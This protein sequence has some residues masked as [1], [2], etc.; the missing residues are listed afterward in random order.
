MSTADETEAVTG[1]PTVNQE[2]TGMPGINQ[3]GSFFGLKTPEMQLEETTKLQ[4]VAKQT[5]EIFQAN[6]NGTIQ[7]RR[8]IEMQRTKRRI[9]EQLENVK[10]LNKQ[11]TYYMVQAGVSCEEVANFTYQ[12]DVSLDIY[13]DMVLQ[14]AEELQSV[15]GSK[16]EQSISEPSTNERAK[17]PKLELTTYGGEPLKWLEFWEQFNSVIHKS[18]LA[19]T[20]K[21]HY[22]RKVLVGRA[23]AVIKGLPTTEENY[24]VAIDKLLKEFGDDSKLRSAHVKAIRDIPSVSNAHN[25]YKLRR[26]Y[27]EISANYA[28]LESMNYEEQVMCLVEETVMKLPRSIRYEITKDDRQWTQWKFPQF[29]DKLWNYLKACEE[30]EPMESP[31]NVADLHKRSVAHT[32]TNRAVECVYCKSTDH[33]SFQ[34]TSVVS[35]A[36]RKAILQ[37]QKRCFNCTRA[38][39]TLRQ[40]KSRNLCYHCKGKHHSSICA[41]ANT[42]TT[43]AT[44]AGTGSST[45]DGVQ[46]IRNGP[47]AYQTVQ[48]K[49]GGEI[50]RI[51]L[52]SGSGKSYISREHSRK[53]KLKP[54]RKESRIIGTVNGEMEVNCPIYNLEVNGVGNATGKF[55]T[56]FAELDLFMLSSVP[57]IHPE[58][59]RKKYPHLKG[60]WFSDVSGDNELPIHAI[61]GVKDYA[62][63]RTGRMVKGNQHEPIAEETTLGWTLMGAIQ[64]H[65]RDTDRSSVNV[66]VEKPSSIAEDFKLLYDL[67]ILGIKD[68]SE[69]VYEEFKDNITRLSDGRYSVKLPWRKGQYYLPNNKQLCETRLKSLLKK[70]RGDQETLEAYDAVIKSQLEEGIVEVVPEQPDGER[71]SYLPHH[72]VIRKEAETTKLRIVYDASA[73][74]RKYDKSLNE[75]LHIGP[76]LQ[77]MLYDILLRFR[78]FPVAILGDIEKAFLQIEVSKEDRDAMRFLWVK[79][80]H[81]EPPEICELRFTRVIFGSGP[82]PF[83][84][85]ATIKEHMESYKNEDPEFVNLVTKSLFVDD[86]AAGGKN[87][88]EVAVLK[89]KLKERF[90][91]GHFNMRKWKSNDADLRE[92]TEKI[93]T[94]G[95]TA[96]K[97]DSQTKVLGVS[98]KQETDEMA[99]DFEKICSLEHEPTQRGILR[100]VA[101]TYDPLGT[102]SPVSIVAKIMYHDA[103]MQKQGWDEPVNPDILKKWEKWLKEL[104]EHKMIT[105]SRCLLAY[106]KEDII[107]IQLHG[108]AD[109]SVKACCAAIYLVITQTSGTYAKLLTAKSRVAKPNMSVPRLELIGAQMLTKLIQN[110]KSALSEEIHETRGWLDSQTVLCWL[111]NKG[112]YKQFVRTRIDQILEA[113]D[114]KWNYCPTQDNPADLGTRGTTSTELQ[115]NQT[116][117][118][119]P[120]WLTDED[121]WPEQPE[122]LENATDQEERRET[123]I[124]TTTTVQT[125]GLSNCIDINRFNS[126]LKMFRVTVWILRFVNKARKKSTET[127]EEPTKEEIDATEVMWARESQRL[128]PPSKQQINQLGL[129]SDK[130]GVLRCHGRFDL[131]EEQQPVYIPKQHQLA[132]KLATDAHKR[133]MHMGVETTLA[134]LRSRFW[135]P[136]G[137]QLVKKVIKVCRRCIRFKAKPFNDPT[138]APIPDFRK[139][140]GYAFQSTGVDFAGPFYCKDGKKLKKAYLTLF[141]C[142]TTR[143]VHLELVNDMTAS[144]FRKSLKGLVTRRGAPSLIISDNAKTFKATAR[145]LKSIYKDKR[146]QEF[147]QEQKIDWKFNLSRASWWGGFFER[148]VGVVKNTLKKSLSQAHLKFAEL[149]EIL[150]DVEFSLNNRPLTYQGEDLDSEALTPNH[151]IHGRRIKPM[152]EEEI[153]SD[154]DEVADAKRRLKYLQRC[155]SRYWNRWSKEYMTSLREHHR[156]TAGKANDIE[157]GDIV[158]IK[159]DN[160]PRNMWKVGKVIKLIQ[161]KDGITRGVTLKTITKGNK[162]EIDRPVQK[163]YPLELKAKT[164]EEYQEKENND[165]ELAGT[166]NE[167]PKRRAAVHAGNEIKT[168]LMLEEEN[169]NSV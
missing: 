128:Y 148:M 41:I 4:N 63:I 158:L 130:N 46:H 97:E 122:Y 145:W 61:L 121:K 108:F 17:V 91:E 156:I 43:T 109:S 161:G 155:K 94:Q 52:D 152:K 26:F 149:Q 168:T 167:R 75:C 51:L 36:E 54:S 21:F 49:V 86:L 73:K 38:N 135:I 22:L 47:V 92:E 24:M 116:W 66:M 76:P 112:E 123:T 131:Q 20:M 104:A 44:A 164:C 110:V 27:E 8:P 169:Q 64:E 30:I 153:F 113:E 70:L 89:Q 98:W 144:T 154:E 80:I 96:V 150:L 83:L 12:S 32:T 1:E 72:G 6:I 87:T 15:E 31:R 103:C 78:M 48:A 138:T 100:T 95:S 58:I 106:P 119:G 13:E 127:S 2:G 114:I 57:N 151:L 10:Q 42:T 14:L 133:T 71:V 120:E 162:Y 56:E 7:R 84:L 19:T 166:M 143:A 33:K 163:L 40:C 136:N 129:M 101:A 28:S 134:E 29:L 74:Q 55:T 62:H 115:E 69:D 137:R 140:P 147:L 3:P 81:Q 141:T 9:E 126:A 65:Q 11:M 142:A 39:H 85:G 16:D 77:P 117:W 160:L 23:A 93:P 37:G 59:Q 124:L 90:N 35:I 68:N 60:I 146:V 125:T 111:Q 157:A 118:N 50:C 53:L 45:T 79:D 82:S 159:D 139:T 18:S 5:L 67:D 132:F 25:L 34:C 102:A 88:N 99:V 107:S 165:D 105:F